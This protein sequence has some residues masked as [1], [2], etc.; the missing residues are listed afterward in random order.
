MAH[1]PDLFPSL[2]KALD[3]RYHIQR[4]LGR[5]GMGIVYL[6]TE[7][8]LDRPVAL[9]LLPPA[10]A[11][12]P[13]RREQF[14]REARTAARLSHPNIVPIFAVDHVDEFV[15]FTM[16]YVEGETLGHRIRTRGAMPPDEAARV[17][18][19]VAWAVAYA[20]AQGVIHR[21]VKAENILLE[22]GSDRVLITDFGIAHVMSEGEVAETGLMAG[23]P[24]YMSPE[25]VLGARVDERSDVYSL[26]VTGY[27][28]VSGRVPFEG[29]T[30][31]EILDQH[32]NRPAPPIETPGGDRD[33]R[34]VRAV[35]RCLAKRPEDRFQTAA[36]L[37]EALDVPRDVPAP[38]RVFLEK[39][40]S[41]AR[42]GAG[43]SVLAAVALVQV[44][45]ALARGQWGGA[46][47]A[48]GFMALVLA[49]PVAFLLPLT[50]RVLKAGHTR[51]DIVRAL[52]I[53]V[54]R[55]RE[56]LAFRFGRGEGRLERIARRTVYAG[57]GLFG[58][59]LVSNLIGVGADLVVGSMALGAGTTIVAG[60]IAAHRSQRRSHRA[61]RLWLAF[62]RSRFGTLVTKLSGLGIAR[63][64][65]GGARDARRAESAIATAAIR[66]YQNLPEGVREALGD[67]PAVVRQLEVKTQYTRDY[68]AELEANLSDSDSAP[69]ALADAHEETQR[70]LAA[71]VTAL[72]RIRLE[73]RQLEAG[74]GT[75][76]GVS[77]EL[78]AAREIQ[79]AVDRLLAARAEMRGAVGEGSRDPFPKLRVP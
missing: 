61:A 69:S 14:L 64:P 26:G 41:T 29:R 54:D 55:K 56:E 8:A 38:L 15:F 35:E 27:F 2:A 39:S 49:A 18:H 51:A 20:H 43:V 4:E 22:E 60:S 71:V 62:W 67:L 70:G 58:F 23:T 50:R 75:V 12:E 1:A 52:S 28:A 46:A 7:L 11:L 16:A 19:E 37:A 6:A 79:Q 57:L 10:V 33:H 42:Y 65:A 73:L 74:A 77:A 13:R 47:L 45:S 30:A 48:G 24:K 76:E 40:R 3:G 53:D 17:L 66:L 21:D 9:K 31:Q 63:L 72:E 59:G 32:V 36:D 44:I 25:Q 34:L 78:A 68:I 5:G